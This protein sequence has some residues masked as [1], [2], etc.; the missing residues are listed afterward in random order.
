MFHPVALQS[1]RE[2]KLYSKY[3]SYGDKLKKMF[4]QNQAIMVS[5]F[6]KISVLPLETH[7]R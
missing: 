3:F 1:L 7:W 5:T 6:P 4:K 2:L